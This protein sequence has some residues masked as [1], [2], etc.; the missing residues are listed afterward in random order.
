MRLMKDDTLLN[1]VADSPKPLPSF[2]RKRDGFSRTDVV[3]AL[4]RAFHMIG[5]VQ[6]LAIWANAN[7]TE[8]YKLYGKLLPATTVNIGEV[9]QTTIIHAIPPTAL[10]VHEI[11][12]LIV[13]ATSREVIPAAVENKTP[14]ANG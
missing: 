5:G 10:D 14:A 8:F 9:N 3:E 1:A 7:P 12:A 11:P 4:H 6:R 13:D 2:S